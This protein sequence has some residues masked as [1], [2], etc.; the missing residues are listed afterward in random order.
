M[1]KL[2]IIVLAF[3][4]VPAMGQRFQGGLLAGLTACQ[5]DGDT[6][7]GYNKAGLLGGVFV[8]TDFSNKLS[9][10]LELKYI[11]KGAGTKNNDSNTNYYRVNMQYLE[12]PVLA[13]YRVYKLLVA[14]LGIGAGYLFK[15]QKD[16]GNGYLDF[17]PPLNNFELSGIAG[18]HYEL[19]KHISV[20]A[21]FQYS[22]FPVLPFGVDVPSYQISGFYNNI[23]SFAFYYEIGK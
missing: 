9:G 2:L 8:K 6:Y 22:L 7:S 14:E 18:V 5:I 15:A 1:R 20:N 23:I 10:Q 16:D 11:S 17:E 12:I 19:F 21:R 3:A 4:A 13:R